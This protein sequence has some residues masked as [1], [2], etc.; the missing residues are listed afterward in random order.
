MGHG[1]P[2]WYRYRS[3]GN[4]H[5]VLDLG[6]VAARLGSIDTF[7]RRGDVIWLDTFEEGM[8]KWEPFTPTSG[9]S[10]NPSSYVARNGGL[11]MKF[12][13]PAILLS[14]AQIE[15][16]MGVPPLAAMGLEM[17]FT[18]AADIQE[19]G[20]IFNIFTGTR[21]YLSRAYYVHAESKVQYM[22]SGG[23]RADAAT[24]VV[25]REDDY[26]WNTMKLVVDFENEN[27]MRLI[28]NGETYLADH[29]AIIADGLVTT[30]RFHQQIWVESALQANK[31]VYIDDI[32]L[33]VNEP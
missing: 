6:D 15:R 12:T 7:D 28:L 1:L 8:N 26:T 21:R 16:N 9:G 4:I 14:V 17:S 3:F 22:P 24:N 25:L 18:M 10:V 27:Y 5:K 30:P 11:S 20:L 23:G 31:T 29:P 32:I 33:T 19:V 2:S 13:T